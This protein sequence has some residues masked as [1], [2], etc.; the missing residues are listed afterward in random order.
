VK[1]IVVVVV[2]AVLANGAKSLRHVR[3]DE[4]NTRPEER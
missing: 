4:R 1:S 2:V 3:V